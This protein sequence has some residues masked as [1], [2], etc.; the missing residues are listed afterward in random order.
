MK[1]P[2]PIPRQPANSHHKV[3][4]PWLSTSAIRATGCGRGKPICAA[5]LTG[6]V[7]RPVT[8]TG[9]LSKPVVSSCSAKGYSDEAVWNILASIQF[10]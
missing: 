1:S 4:V 3:A 8:I 5:N 6:K 9:Q 7:E 10:K 2:S